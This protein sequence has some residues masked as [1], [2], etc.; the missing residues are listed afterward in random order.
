VA[1]REDGTRSYLA[2]LFG[3][4]VLVFAGIGLANP[5]FVSGASL[6]SMAFQFPEFGLL[7]LA[8]L[9]TMLS[10]GIDLSVV[11]IA[12]LTSI[13]AALLLKSGHE[14]F[15]LPL[16][17]GV[18]VACGILNGVLIGVLRL[19]A[20][21]ATLGTMQAVG[22]L[23]IVITGG[24]AVTGLPDW[25]AAA[26]NAAPG[27][28]PVPLI[29]FVAVLVALGVLLRYS[30]T[31]VQARLYGANPVAARFAGIPEQRLIT[32]IYV[33]SGIVSALA[34]LLILGHANSAYADYGTSYVLL[35]VLINI[36]AGVN[37]A[38]GSGTVIGVLLAV[39][40]L[41]LISSGLN[42]LSFSAFLRDLFFG[43]LLVI[44][45]SLRVL[46]GQLRLTAWLA[47][48]PV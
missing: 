42:F 18:G 27:G 46:A 15:A 3:L 35:V 30:S 22:G 16:A 40:L 44:V 11:S 5:S 1:Q 13:V 47:R 19:P 9:P 25:Y 41:Q 24:P 17:L 26:V 43:L 34:G 20:I 4:L 23:G 36:L 7:A 21:L 14:G 12:N 38:G 31:G 45:M 6:S 29:V 48:R 32:I 33:A 10:G 2:A 39:L 8:I 37:P 28:I